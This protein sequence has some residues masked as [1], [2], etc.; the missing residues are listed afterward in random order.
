[1]LF[2]SIHQHSKQLAQLIGDR[3]AVE[4]EQRLLIM[5]L[6]CDESMTAFT[7]K[8][9]VGWRLLGGYLTPYQ[10]QPHS[11]EFYEIQPKL[12]TFVNHHNSIGGKLRQA[13]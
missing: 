1:M 6:L 12:F 10:P 3:M 13:F 5:G 4:N 7:E 8:C 9:L 2:Q 11:N